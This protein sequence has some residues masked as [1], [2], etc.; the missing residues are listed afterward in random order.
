[1]LQ[2]DCT[3][4]LT[5]WQHLPAD[6]IPWPSYDAGVMT[7]AER[8]QQLN[9]SFYRGD[10]ADYIFTRLAI[11]MAFEHDTP[12]VTQSLASGLE[13]HGVR[14]RTE[15]E[16]PVEA[17]E[18]AK[19]VTIES[20]LLAHHAVEALLRLFL[21]HCSQPEC[22]ALIVASLT[23]PAQFRERLAMILDDGLLDDLQ[24]EV[25]MNVVGIGRE[26]GADRLALRDNCAYLFRDL[27]E[28]WLRDAAL[29][30]ALKHGLAGAPGSAVFRLGTQPG[31]EHMT[32]VGEGA[33]I[34][35]L[36]RA[37]VEGQGDVWQSVTSWIDLNE[38]FGAITLSLQLI[39]NIWSLAR[40]R[41]VASVAPIQLQV[42]TVRLKDLAKPSGMVRD[43]AFNHFQVIKPSRKQ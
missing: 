7:D 17:V 29:Y 27:A 31:D 21:G 3:P 5:T 42:P 22:P 26:D 34:E 2:A 32:V 12:R 15:P 18:V 25:G 33:S 19:Y 40:W 37:R 10:P 39:Q 16:P 24:R 8:F 38:T 1:M 43:V 28:F 20:T 35:Y 30:N 6:L 14:I 4:R 41:Y 13:L 11:L 9:E 36:R 23:S